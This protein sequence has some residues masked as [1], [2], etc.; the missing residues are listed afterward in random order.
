MDLLGQLGVHT[1]GDLRTGEE[2]EQYAGRWWSPPA[3]CHGAAWCAF[4][5][6]CPP[7]VS[8]P[9]NSGWP[10]AVRASAAP[11][12]VFAPVRVGGHLGGRRAAVDIHGCA[13]RPAQRRAAAL[14]HVRH[15]AQR[16][17]GRPADALRARAGLAGDRGDGDAAQRAGR[18]VHR[19]SV[20]GPAH[21]FRTR[22]GRQPRS[23]SRSPQRNGRRFTT[24]ECA[25]PNHFWQ[26]GAFSSTCGIVGIPLRIDINGP[27]G[28]LSPQPPWRSRSV[29]GWRPAT[30]S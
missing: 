25:P 4:P 23:I 1:F 21:D 15:Q 16:T 19:R 6:T 18:R 22:P 10:R 26:R 20:H 2:Q 29:G 24:P 17:L 11:P 28:P 30:V 27:R 7:T 12:Y 9:T 3:T 8:T 5:G 14:A 13:L